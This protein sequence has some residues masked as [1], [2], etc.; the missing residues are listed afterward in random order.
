MSRPLVS[1][2]G[3][4]AFQVSADR[5]VL[6]RAEELRHGHADPG[7]PG[8]RSCATVPGA[9]LGGVA[10]AGRKPLRAGGFTCAFILGLENSA[11]EDSGGHGGAESCGGT[12]VHELQG[13]L[14]PP[15]EAGDGGR[16]GLP[17]SQRPP[18][19]PHRTMYGLP[20]SP[21][22]AAGTLQEPCLPTL[23]HGSDS[24]G[25]YGCLLAAP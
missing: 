3:E 25:A 21:A 18:P 12:S 5:K 9:S 6:L 15:G 23:P 24:R 10:A 19:R 14:N 2:A 16:D 20:V 11:C 17:A 22:E 4:P 13:A 1:A 7:R 8:A